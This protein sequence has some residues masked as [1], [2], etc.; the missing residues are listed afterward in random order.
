MDTDG[1]IIVTRPPKEQVAVESMAFPVICRSNAQAVFFFVAAVQFSLAKKEWE[2]CYLSGS[3]RR[4]VHP[5][6]RYFVL[7]RGAQASVTA[8]MF[9]ILG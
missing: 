7:N 8:G 3:S 1:C 4:S 5:E 2:V 6:T 9:L